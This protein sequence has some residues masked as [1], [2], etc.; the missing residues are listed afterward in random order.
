MFLPP[1]VDR[2]RREPVWD[3]F[4]MIWMDTDVDAELPRIV[5]AAAT[6]CYSIADLHH[7]YWH[8]VR[9]VV[10]KNM[11]IPVA[12]EWAGYEIKWLG[13]KIIE[14]LASGKKS[15][16]IKFHRYARGYWAKIESGVRIARENLDP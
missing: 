2:V 15:L 3:A 5:N 8:E 16:P 4:Q 12:P 11:L 10:W 7:I 6:S 13:D 1:S 14:R 9:P